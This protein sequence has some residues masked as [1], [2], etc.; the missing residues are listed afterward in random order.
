[1][2]L[3]IS[4]VPTMHGERVVIRILDSKNMPVGLEGLGFDAPVLGR[5]GRWLTQPNGIVL[6]TG[7]T[8]SGKSTTLYGALQTMDAQQQNIIT[9]EDP[10][11]YQLASKKIRE[12]KPTPSY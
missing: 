6:V 5:F 10:I 9:V 2:D 3:R 1:V 4:I 12:Q 8:G 11:E 7:P